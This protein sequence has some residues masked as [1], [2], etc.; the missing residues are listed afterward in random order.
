MELKER[1]ARKPVKVAR[2]LLT[3][4]C[5]LCG[6]AITPSQ[7][8]QEAGQHKAHALCVKNPRKTCVP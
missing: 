1:L 7:Q 6:Q 4:N 2:R 8:Y 3:K 5:A